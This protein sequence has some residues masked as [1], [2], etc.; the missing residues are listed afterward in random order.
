MAEEEQ[1]DNGWKVMAGYYT[2]SEEQTRQEMRDLAKIVH[3]VQPEALRVRMGER[4]GRKGMFV[5]YAESPKT[6]PESERLD[7]NISITRG[8]VR[9][10]LE[11]AANVILGTEPGKSMVYFLKRISDKGE[12]VYDAYLA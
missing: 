5:D 4:E 10:G 6:I 8:E 11:A 2:C 3:A 7:S 12:P 9:S 1:R